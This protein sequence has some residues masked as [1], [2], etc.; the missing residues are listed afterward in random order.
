MLPSGM[1]ER[2]RPRRW[3]SPTPAAANSDAERG[4]HL[5]QDRRPAD[6]IDQPPPFLSGAMAGGRSQAKMVAAPASRRARGRRRSRAWARSS[7]GC[8]RRVI[9]QRACR[10]A[11]SNGM[12]SA[13][14]NSLLPSRSRPALALF[15]A[16]RRRVAAA[17]QSEP[18]EPDERE[19]QHAVGEIAE[20]VAAEKLSAISPQ[21]AALPKRLRFA[22]ST[23][24][25]KRER[26]EHR[27]R[28][29]RRA[30]GA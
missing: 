16:G 9:V 10:R 21:K 20:P 17:D 24:D 30:N 26:R 6:R 12:I 22:R 19:D 5:R 11:R 8:R 14:R 13:G 29:E 4:E 23:R 7:R 2:R 15:V 28:Q 18:G 25:S 3:S 27:A 1:I